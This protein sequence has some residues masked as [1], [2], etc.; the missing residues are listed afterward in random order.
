MIDRYWELLVSSF[1]CSTAYPFGSP[2]EGNFLVKKLC[3]FEKSL[4]LWKPGPLNVADIFCPVREV[5][6]CRH[7]G[8]VPNFLSFAHTYSGATGGE[9]LLLCLSDEMAAGASA[10]HNLPQLGVEINFSTL[11]SKTSAGTKHPFYGPIRAPPW[12][13]SQLRRNSILPLQSSHTKTRRKL[14]HLSMSARRKQAL[15]LTD[16]RLTRRKWRIWYLGD[17]LG[18]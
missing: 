9:K 15:A 10:S 17:Q 18:I 8:L 14:P 6:S 12:K 2:P 13:A 7:S 11:A 16:L 3:R 4:P 1:F 5:K